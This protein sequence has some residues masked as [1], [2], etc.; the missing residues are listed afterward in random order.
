[1][2]LG[3]HD[4]CHDGRARRSHRHGP[5]WSEGEIVTKRSQTPGGP[6]G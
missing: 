5:G 6:S 4:W 2:R 3:Q 1:M